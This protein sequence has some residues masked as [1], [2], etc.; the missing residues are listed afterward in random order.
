VDVTKFKWMTEAG[1]DTLRG[2]SVYTE[3]MI[4]LLGRGRGPAAFVVHHLFHESGA[5][6]VN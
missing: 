3:L 2:L 6:K 4:S 5:E 1:L